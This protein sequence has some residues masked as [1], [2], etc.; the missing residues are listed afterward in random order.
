MTTDKRSTRVVT[1]EHEG[2][3]STRPDKNKAQLKP[4]SMHSS[5]IT[6]K[7]TLSPQKERN[8]LHARHTKPDVLRMWRVVRLL[9]RSRNFF[10]CRCKI[11]VKCSDAKNSHD[12][13]KTTL[14]NPSCGPF[15]LHMSTRAIHC[16]TVGATFGQILNRP[17]REDSK[18]HQSHGT[19]DLS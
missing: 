19:H 15:V 2:S 8:R 14:E 12:T 11:C 1:A 17:K 18:E 9:H 10:G 6:V 5:T 3:Q 13:K 4:W 7:E 16:F